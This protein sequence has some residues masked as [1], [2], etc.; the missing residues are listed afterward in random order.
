MQNMQNSIDPR[1]ISFEV[2]CLLCNLMAPGGRRLWPNAPAYIQNQCP[3]MVSNR[4]Q[5]RQEISLLSSE[6]ARACLLQE[7][8]NLLGWLDDIFD[9]GACHCQLNTSF[10]MRLNLS[11]FL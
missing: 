7:D 9:L 6:V 10:R 5:R 1:Q 4:V 3:R 11:S 2:Y 8:C